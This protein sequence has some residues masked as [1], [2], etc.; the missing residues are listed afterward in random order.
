[1]M[2][3][4]VL[5]AFAAYLGVTFLVVALAVRWAGRNGRRGWLWGGIAAFAMYNLV[6]WDWIP[7]VAMHKY[8]CA[9]EAGFWVYKTPEQWAKEN[10]GVL[11]TLERWPNQKIYGSQKVRFELNGGEARQYNDRFGHWI[12]RDSDIL[13]LPLTRTSYGIVD[14]K[15]REFLAVSTTFAAGPRGGPEFTWK[16]WLH[17]GRCEGEDITARDEAYNRI[18]KLLKMRDDNND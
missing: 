10:P 7:T 13:G 1:M 12:R 6:F 15:T 11:E 18:S 16:S 17:T 3:L 8:Y 9:T 2:G 14:T 4:M 5:L